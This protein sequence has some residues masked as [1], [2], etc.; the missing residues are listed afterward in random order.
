M[1]KVAIR[2][3][4][5]F[6]LLERK[7]GDH[8]VRQLRQSCVKGT[9]QISREACLALL[10]LV[11]WHGPEK[12]D[13]AVGIDH[14]ESLDTVMGFHSLELSDIEKGLN[15]GVLNL[16]YARLIGDDETEPGTD[17][18]ESVISVL[19]EGFAKILLLS[20]K[21]QGLSTSSHISLLVRL[22]S[23]YFGDETKDLQRY[24]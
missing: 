22:I 18:E 6:G 20:D 2:C 3:L 11:T 10:D 24:E 1:Q 7:P 17:E 12:I 21:Y 23:L 19:G 16:L 9:P 14:A 15:I 8:L 5:L 4:G 13:Q